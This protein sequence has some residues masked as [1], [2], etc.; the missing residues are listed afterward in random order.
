MAYTIDPYAELERH[1]PKSQVKRIRRL[2]GPDSELSGGEKIRAGAAFSQIGRG[3]NRDGIA[4]I[5]ALK[6]EKRIARG[7]VSDA[8]VR[9]FVEPAYEEDALR[10]KVAMSL[11]PKA[12]L[13]EAWRVK[14]GGGQVK[15]E[16]GPPADG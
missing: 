14:R 2:F 13:P 5:V 3:G 12:E 1:L 11:L 16:I 8:G 10:E 6:G 15:A 4:D 7:N 9:F